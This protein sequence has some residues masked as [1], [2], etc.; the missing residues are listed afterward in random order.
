MDGFL[1]LLA[2]AL[3]VALLMLR[4]YG[5]RLRRRPTFRQALAELERAAQI[6]RLLE[7][8]REAEQLRHARTMGDEERERAALLAADVAFIALQ[9]ARRREQNNRH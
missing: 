8:Q 2:L 7:I 6:R 4:A 3:F 5:P 9:A 1:L